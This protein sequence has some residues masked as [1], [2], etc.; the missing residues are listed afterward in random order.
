MA[1]IIRSEILVLDVNILIDFMWATGVIIPYTKY[2]VEKLI[3][4]TTIT[5]P[6]DCIY[7]MKY[8]YNK[9]LLHWDVIT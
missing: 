4:W 9:S 3:S 6:A 1:Y 8:G 7:Y 2:K 5:C